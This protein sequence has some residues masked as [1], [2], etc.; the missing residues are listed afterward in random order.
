VI[1]AAAAYRWSS[2][3]LPLK[4]SEINPATKADA[5][6]G[7][8]ARGSVIY[9]FDNSELLGVVNKQG[10]ELDAGKYIRR[11]NA[12]CRDNAATKVRQCVATA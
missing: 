12:E 6:A 11:L 8:F 9:P 2:D 4:S 1:L 3:L 10:Y 5:A 7:D